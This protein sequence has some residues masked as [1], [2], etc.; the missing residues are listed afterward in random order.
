MSLT[1]SDDRVASGVVTRSTGK[2][3]AAEN[4]RMMRMQFEFQAKISYPW[5][6]RTDGDLDDW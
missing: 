4:A 2:V 6:I 5:A 3:V 1:Q